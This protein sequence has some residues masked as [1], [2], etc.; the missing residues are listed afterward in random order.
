MTSIPRRQYA[1]LYGPSTGDRVRL[2]DTA[3]IAEVERDLLVPGEEVVYGGGKTFRD[4]MGQT[5][6]VRNADGALDT[7]ITAALV[8]DPVLGIVKAD[9]GIKDGRIAGVGKAG[10]PYVQDGVDPNLVVGPG[11]EA[12]SGEGLIA[13]AGGVDSHVHL[14]TSAQV[15]HALSNGVTTLLGGGTGPTDGSKGT[16]CTPGPWNLARMLEATAALPVNIG[17]LGK[18]NTSRPESARE[19]L[20][21]GACGLKVHEDWGATGTTIDCALAVADEYDVQVAIHTDSMNE[22]GFLADTIDAIDGRVIHTYHTEGAGGG[23]APDIMA[24]AGLPHVLPSST[25]PT[26]PYTT[27]S[28]DAMFYM[29]TVTHHLDPQN[30]EDIAVTNSRIRAE[31]QA[32]EDVLHDLGALSMFSSDSQAMGRV[33]DTV[34]A[35][36]TTADKMKRMTGPLTGDEDGNDNARILRYLA[37]YTIN[38]ALTHGISHLVGSLEPG[39]VADIVLWPTNTF[40]AKPKCV[41][42]GGMLAWTIMGDPNASIPTPEPVLLRPAFG[43]EGEAVGRTSMTLVSRAAAEA[44]L[45]ERLPSRWVEPVRGCRTLGKGQMVRNSATPDIRVDLETYRVSVD[46]QPATVDPAESVSLSQLYYIV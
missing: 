16:T 1:T 2:A 40:G 34:T 43:A 25:T 41:L 23:H 20:A 24:I 6:G 27:D 12:L 7:V 38:P 18:G 4:G 36:W 37:K 11:T 46:G 9:I 21:A 17:L 3:L 32:A 33:G 8:M 42:K 30:P 28:T 14:L 10:N 19:Q 29:A 31:T 22:G 13:T 39:K 44:G 26:K 45:A 5:P 35:C 15:P